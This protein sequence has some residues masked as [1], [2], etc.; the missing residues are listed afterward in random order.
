MRIMITFKQIDRDNYM[1]CICLKVKESQ[2]N[3]V[4][5]NA[6]SL[7]EAQ[8][9]EGIYTRAIYADDTLVGFVLYDYDSEI[10]G[11]SMSR[12]MI[13]EQYQGQGL[14]KI[15]VIEF[16]KYLKEQMR[17]KEIYISVE[18]ENI[19]AYEM[20]RKIGFVDVKPVQYEFD[21]TT[22]YEMQM[23]IEL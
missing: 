18:R 17:I 15:A 11:W 3:F 16:L 12:F 2:Q 7:V 21:G 13:G 10:P 8:F 1:E 5:D 14:G 20:Y 19:V 4:A 22:Y 6:R 9:E 23:K